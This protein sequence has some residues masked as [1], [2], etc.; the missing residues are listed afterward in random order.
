MAVWHECYQ[1]KILVCIPFLYLV[2]FVMLIMQYR[3]QF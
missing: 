2:V 1:S 3:L